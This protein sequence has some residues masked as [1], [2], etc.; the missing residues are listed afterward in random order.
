MRDPDRGDPAATG[1]GRRGRAVFE[2]TLEHGV[3]PTRHGESARE[4]HDRRSGCVHVD[5]VDAR[6]AGVYG[7]A[8]SVGVGSAR[9]TRGESESH[10]G[11]AIGTGDIPGRANNITSRTGSVT[12]GQSVIWF[13]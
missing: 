7:I 9:G 8:I 6:L 10:A 12:V 1:Q 5:S 11:A 4:D 2:L 13:F 3:W